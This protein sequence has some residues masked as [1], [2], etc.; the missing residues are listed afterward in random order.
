MEAWV[1]VSFLAS[2]TL[3]SSLLIKLFRLTPTISL[4]SFI[5]AV[6]CSHY[7]RV[8]Q[9]KK[10]RAVFPL[11]RERKGPHRSAPPLRGSFR[12]LYFVGRMIASIMT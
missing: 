5:N 11:L 12:T 10:S 3:S 7:H 8:L 4:S 1:T 6:L 9:K 2:H